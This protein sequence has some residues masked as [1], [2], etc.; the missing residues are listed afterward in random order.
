MC[1][2]QVTFL[3]DGL[4]QFGFGQKGRSEDIDLGNLKLTVLCLLYLFVL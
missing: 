4:V 1:E 2:H 3:G